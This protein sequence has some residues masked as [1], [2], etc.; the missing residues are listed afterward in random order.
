[1]TEDNKENC[2][3]QQNYNVFGLDDK[4]CCYLY[5]KYC[6]EIDSCYFKRCKRL[7]QENKASEKQIELDVEHICRLNEQIE[8]LEQENRE[9]QAYKDINED[10][11]KAWDELNEKYKQ[12]RSALEEIRILATKNVSIEN[13][14]K[15]Q[16]KINEV[17][18]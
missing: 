13:F 9:L 15:I 5:H 8:K 11:K 4:P 7:E 6:D 12:L 16:I 17:L 14:V 2:N 18:K 10:F 1:M 3:F